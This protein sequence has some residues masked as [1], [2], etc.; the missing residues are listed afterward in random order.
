MSSTALL[1]CRRVVIALNWANIYRSLPIGL[2]WRSLGISEVIAGSE[3]EREFVKRS[4]GLDSTVIVSGTD[5]QLFKPA[6]AKRCQV[7]FMP[8]KHADVFHLIACVFRSRFP[9]FGHVPFVPIDG[10]AH[11]DVPRVLSESA[12]FLA[13]S[14]PE[15]L[16]RPPLEAMACGC[17]VV[18]FAGRGSL[19]YMDHLR[20]CYLAEDMDVLTAAELLGTA[21]RSFQDGSAEPMQVAARNTA[22]RYSLEREEHTV[23]RYWSEFLA[24]PRDAAERRPCA[25]SKSL[26][27]TPKTQQHPA[28]Q[29]LSCAGLPLP[30]EA[31]RKSVFDGVYDR[32]VREIPGPGIVVDVGAGMGASTGYLAH[33]VKESSKD[34]RVFAIDMFTTSGLSAIAER[35]TKHE[36][37]FHIFCDNMRRANVAEYV[38]PLIGDSCSSAGRFPNQSLDFVYFGANHEYEHVRRDILAWL[39]KLKPERPMAGKGYDASHPGVVKAVREMFGP[40]S[41]ESMG[42]S[43]FVSRPLA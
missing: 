25:D 8:R 17:L 32:A 1:P 3:Y 23:T 20:N 33:R 14:F 36:S 34:L 11:R 37:V 13:T 39:P 4:M 43:W 10:V 19:E 38:T 31:L 42:R 28:I 21:L 40:A 7:A 24:R 16:A 22:L 9:E 2:D 6:A 27:A 18:G 35:G 26:P 12:C 15:G 29:P 5:S 30:A 41:V